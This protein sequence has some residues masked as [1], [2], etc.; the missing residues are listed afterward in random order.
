[1]PRNKYTHNLGMKMTTRSTRRDQGKSD[2]G[3]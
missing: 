3:S 2:S 1:M